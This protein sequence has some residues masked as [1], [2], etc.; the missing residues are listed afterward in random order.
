MDTSE[1][2][3]SR[4][5]RGAPLQTGA[6]LISYGESSGL[7]SLGAFVALIIDGARWQLSGAGSGE[8]LLHLLALDLCTLTPL[9]ILLTLFLPPL[10]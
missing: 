3:Q 1:S 5:E 6:G 4:G 10:A 9:V 7:F 2:K 8:G